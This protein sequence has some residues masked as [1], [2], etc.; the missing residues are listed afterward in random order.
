MVQTNMTEKEQVIRILVI[1]DEPQVAEMFERIISREGY[2]CSTAGNAID[3]L[4]ILGQLDYDIAIVDINLPDMSGIELLSRIRGLYDTDIIMITGASET[5]T[6][7]EIIEKGAEDFIFKPVNASE[8]VLRL[9][10]IVKK[11]KL[12]CDLNQAK[13]QISRKL[14]L[15]KSISA[16]LTG[17]LR[18][19]NLDASI[20]FA[21]ESLGKTS[22]AERTSLFLKV[23]E[24]EIANTHE[25]FS[26]GLSSKKDLMQHLALEDFASLLSKLKQGE[27]IR[28][29]SSD[30]VPEL[31]PYLGRMIEQKEKRFLII[32]PV[33]VYKNLEG[34]ICSSIITGRTL[35]KDDEL[36]LLKM[37][38]EI[39]GIGLEKKES[40]RRLQDALERAREADRQKS[41][42][43]ANISHELRTPMNGI[44]GFSDILLKEETSPEKREYIEAIKQSSRH[45]S[46]LLADLIDLS[47]IETGHIQV[48]KKLCSSKDVLMLAV[49]YAKMLLVEQKKEICI[50]MECARDMSEYIYAD[51]M[52]LVQVLNNLMSNA[53]KFTD[54][55][56]ILCA[57]RLA[58][59]GFIEFSVKD[60][61]VGIPREMHTAIFD[62][63]RQLETGFDTKYGGTGL[64]LSITKKLVELMGGRI[65]LVSNQGEAHGTT[66][67]FTIPYEPASEIAA[68]GGA[69]I[70]A[71]RSVIPGHTILLVEDDRISMLLARRILEKNGYMVTAVQNGQD[72]ISAYSDDRENKIDLILMDIHVPLVNGLVATKKIR[73]LEHEKKRAHIPIIALTA[74][75]MKGEKEK[76]IESGCDDF[77]AKPV[78]YDTLVR[79]VDFYIDANC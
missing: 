55:G 4:A 43:V 79:V 26:A 72:A 41:T 40:E 66:F 78:D 35:G 54:R 24:N 60:T 6:Y 2:A 28:I 50:E 21:L 17:F 48:I 67:F 25:W 76:C 12:L 71:E 34:F 37:T 32:Y 59:N 36:D 15:Q 63:F 46:S 1:D 9:A 23:G 44:L 7:A 51:K 49:N 5:Y 20:D 3:A 73:E 65:W 75:A 57:A 14:S 10:R 45:M 11:R 62:A 69:E 52:R 56:N 53:L 38:T 42:F 27:V 30:E 68:Q 58:E 8:V 31:A 61:G 77:V 13:T 70:E 39:I 64:G 29:A 18:E 19:R 47:K 16:I 74:Q 22:G 33:F